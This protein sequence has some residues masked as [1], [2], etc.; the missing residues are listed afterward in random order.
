MKTIM[1]ISAR[2]IVLACALLAV[3]CTYARGGHGLYVGS[4]HN[5]QPVRRPYVQGS[6][7]VPARGTS[8]ARP[9]Q[10]RQPTVRHAP[11]TRRSVRAAPAV[12]ASRRSARPGRPSIGAR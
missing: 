10:R 11:A 3:S 1:N 8:Y 2:L 6:R 7:T 9:A 12:R 5:I 4:G